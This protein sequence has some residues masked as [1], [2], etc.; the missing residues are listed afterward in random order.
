MAKKMTKE[1]Q[2][3]VEIID[4]AIVVSANAGSGKTSTMVERLVT[5]INNHKCSVSEILALTF[6]RSAS[7]EMKQRMFTA[8]QKS[9]VLTEEEKQNELSELNVADICSLDSFCQ[10]IIKKYFYV[11][12]VDPNFGVI[13]EVEAGYLKAT[14]L[15][16]TLSQFSD[17]QELLQFAQMMGATKNLNKINELILNFSEFIFTLK[18]PIEFLDS[19]INDSAK[20]YNLVVQYAL[21]KFKATVLQ[22]KVVLRDAILTIEMNGWDGLKE[23]VQAVYNYCNLFETFKLD[24]TEKLARIPV[25]PKLPNT[26]R[27]KTEEELAYKKE[28]TTLINYVVGKLKDFAHV[29]CFGN[30]NELAQRYDRSLV[31]VKTL[32]RMTKAYI[33]NYAKLKSSRNVLDFTDLEDKAIEILRNSNVNVETRNKYKY[34][35]VDEFQDTN[36]KQSELLSLICG[37]N[38]TF[39]VGDPKQSIYKF[40]QCDLNIFVELI[41]KFKSDKNKEFIPFNQNFRS[42]KHILAFVNKVFN[43]VMTKSVTNIDYKGENQFA[44]LRVLRLKLRGNLRSAPARKIN[45]IDRVRTYYL[46][47]GEDKIHLEC[48]LMIKMRKRLCK[49]SPSLTRNKSNFNNECV[50]K[51]KEATCDFEASSTKKFS[52]IFKTALPN[53]VYSVVTE[54]VKKSETITTDEGDVAV[55]Y[56]AE[57]F[58][59]KIRITDPQTRQKRRVRFSDFVILLR[60]RK[61][62]KNYIDKLNKAGIPVSAKFKINLIKEPCVMNIISI[63][64]TISNPYQDLPLAGSLKIVGKF[65]EREMFEI[66]KVCPENYFYRAYELALV[67]DN[68]SEGLRKKLVDFSQKIKKYRLIAQN[69]TVSQLVSYIIDDCNLKNYYLSLENGVDKLKQVELFLAKISGKSFETSVD[70]FLHF[71]D[72]YEDA[73]KVDYSTVSSDN[74][75]KITTI[76]DS[77]GLEYP[78]TIVGGCGSNFNISKTAEIGYTKELGVACQDFDL[79]KRTKTPSVAHYSVFQNKKNDELLEE[80]RVYYVALTRPKEYLMLVGNAPK[81]GDSDKVWSILDCKTFYEFMLFMEK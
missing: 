75:V 27:G 8:L 18:D 53:P 49:F 79:V 52:K 16:D 40:R 30:V 36:E 37:Q 46:V 48:D 38:N 43:G 54:Q 35:C 26:S 73:F 12:G 55:S 5:L 31:Y 20:Q 39:F 51:L 42:H 74:C 21:D 41:E 32:C 2:M 6:T 44:N 34:V 19:Q 70:E 22:M 67:N 80:M 68:L 9:E 66:R 7:T 56:I 25:F 28:M 77:K 76:H 3:A 69:F 64:R 57:F 47:K 10:K 78:I 63:L 17:S 23:S 4:K 65:S 60:D 61:L 14:A 81:N 1:Q 33:G 62:F 29:F 59:K 13:D 11:K 45:F 71:I 58:E 15:S 72:S 50:E 24:E